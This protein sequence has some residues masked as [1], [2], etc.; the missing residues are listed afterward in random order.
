MGLSHGTLLLMELGTLPCVSCIFLGSSD[1]APPPPA[2]DLF[3]VEVTSCWSLIPSKSTS[4]TSQLVKPPTPYSNV[5]Q[6]MKLDLPSQLLGKSDYH[7][8][9]KTT[10]DAKW[11]KIPEVTRPSPHKFTPSIRFPDLEEGVA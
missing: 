11:K 7:A 6:V 10:F 8:V 3:G 4:L 2:P 1:N 9:G 5:C